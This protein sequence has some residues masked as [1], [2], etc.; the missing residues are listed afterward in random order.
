MD[1]RPHAHEILVAKPS[2]YNQYDAAPGSS[3][4]GYGCIEREVDNDPNRPDA[5]ESPANPCSHLRFFLLEPLILILLFAYNLSATVLQSQIIYQSCTAGLGYTKAV[6]SLLGTK[7]STNETKIIEQE[8]QPYAAHIFLAIKILESLLPAFCGLFVGGLADRY[9]RKPLLL[10]S[11]FGYVL[12]YSLSAC[13]AY[14]A[15][16]LDGMVSPWYYLI[17]IIPISLIGSTVTTTTAA[18]CFIGD[19]STG[20]IRSYRMIAY[21]MS[22]YVGLLLG[23]FAAGYIYDATNAFTIFVISA[24]SILFALLL[25]AALLPESLQNRQRSQGFAL[26]D[27]W[28]TSFRRREHSDRSIL[29]L[30]MCVLLL[31]T[32]VNDGSNSVFYMFMREKFHWTVREFTNYESVSILVPAVAGSGGILFLWS[33]RQCIKSATLWLALISLLSHV[34]SSLMKAFAFVDW[35]IYLAIGL[36]VFKSMVNPMCRTMITN[37]LPDVERGKIF[38]LL[39]VLQ[40][41]SPLASSTLYILFYTLTLSSVPGFFNLISANLYGLAI[42]LLLFVCRKKTN[43]SEHYEQIFK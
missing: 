12:Q 40:S 36:G 43:N 19:V 32:F 26:K 10:A 13:I 6:C 35:Q 42:V 16:Q 39:G 14:I 21:E 37:L 5:V 15:I 8:V 23:S 27:L 11:F 18:L 24:A 20:K 31:A 3:S 41:L 34:S 4:R 38:G 33:L 2:R 17:T 9:G 1:E 30:L 7:N 22:I 29:I 25:M 28:D